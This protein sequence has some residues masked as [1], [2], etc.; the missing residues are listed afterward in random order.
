MR[1]TNEEMDYFFKKLTPV[2]KYYCVGPVGWSGSAMSPNI[3]YDSVPFIHSNGSSIIVTKAATSFLNNLG[4]MANV[5]D[6]VTIR[7]RKRKS[8]PDESKPDKNDRVLDVGKLSALRAQLLKARPSLAI[9]SVRMLLFFRADRK[10]GATEPR[11]LFTITNYTLTPIDL[12]K[13]RE[14]PEDPIH[15]N[16][17]QDASFGSRRAIASFV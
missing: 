16:E 6:V 13:K 15:E 3:G 10:L 17:K 5:H 8:K 11:D 2:G 1:L 4:A 7:A 12:T 9:A 14:G